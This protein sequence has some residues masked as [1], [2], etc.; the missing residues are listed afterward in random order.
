MFG[1][2]RIASQYKTEDR[3]VK[4]MLNLDMVGEPFAQT[5]KLA[6]YSF[7]QIA[8]QPS[9]DPVITILTDLDKS[10]V[11]FSEALTRSYIPEARIYSN[12]C[13]TPCS[14]HCKDLLQSV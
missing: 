2:T 13:G 12:A 11:S 14:D 6:R 1:S 10:L 4:A 9:P 8:Y 3:K 5:L 7:S